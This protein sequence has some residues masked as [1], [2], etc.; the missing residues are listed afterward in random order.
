MN[1]M[2][3]KNNMNKNL[4]NIRDIKSEEEINL[5]LEEFFEECE[6]NK[7]YELKEIHDYTMIL[8]KQ[9]L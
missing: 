1:N 7:N 8:P 6:I 3:N 4:P 9:Y 2:N 5:L